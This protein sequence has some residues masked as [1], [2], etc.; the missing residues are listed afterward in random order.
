M[1]THTWNYSTD[2]KEP[3]RRLAQ[4][5]RNLVRRPRAQLYCF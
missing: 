3:D 2:G 4:G 5:T 1:S